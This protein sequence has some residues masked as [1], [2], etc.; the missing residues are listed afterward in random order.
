MPIDER[1]KSGAD[2]SPAV[3]EHNDRRRSGP[4]HTVSAVV[5]VVELR[6]GSRLNSRISDLGLGGCYIDTITP[7]PLGSGVRLGLLKGK[8]VVE[9]DGK[10]IYS[11]PGLGMGIAFTTAS[12]EQR[13]ALD[14]WVA[15]LAELHVA[16][17]TL[18]PMVAADQAAPL[19]P[20]QKQLATLIHLLIDKGVLAEEEVRE[21]LKKPVL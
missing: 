20:E 12:P 14:R 9:V 11:H 10:A 18:E 7:L 8:Q 3:I 4:R 21:L 15:E 17:V 16:P 6:S 2:S 13:A 19:T 1:P 5:Q